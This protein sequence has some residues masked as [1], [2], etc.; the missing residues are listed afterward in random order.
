LTSS[1]VV[2]VDVGVVGGGEMGVVDVE[3]AGAVVGAVVC[4]VGVED[5]RWL[6]VDLAGVVCVTVP[7]LVPVL[8]APAVDGRS[9]AVVGDAGWLAEC[10]GE[11]VAPV[12]ADPW[13]PQLVSSTATTAA[14]P[15]RATP[16]PAAARRRFPRGKPRARSG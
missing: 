10:D 11:S 15:H 7:R 2:G 13:L 6:G 3:L 4:C 16:T 5:C 1:G 12:F 8:A 9:D 14:T